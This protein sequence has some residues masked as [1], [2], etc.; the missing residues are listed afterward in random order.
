MKLSTREVQFGFIPIAD[1][2]LRV[3]L[4]Y[5]RKYDNSIFVNTFD[6]TKFSCFTL[7]LSSTTFSLET[8]NLFAVQEN[9]QLE[10][11]SL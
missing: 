9:N 5:S 11:F 8:I 7:P 2:M 4:Y 3:S 6:K 10:T 1:S